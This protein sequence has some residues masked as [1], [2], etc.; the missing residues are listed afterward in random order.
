MLWGKE[1]TC[2]NLHVIN[3]MSLVAVKFPSRWKKKREAVY[4]SGDSIGPPKDLGN[5]GK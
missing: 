4:E 3:H 5:E 1:K 2:M